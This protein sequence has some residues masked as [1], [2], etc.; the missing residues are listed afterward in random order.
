MALLNTIVDFCYGRT[1]SSG[2]MP[3]LLVAFAPAVYRPACIIYA[4]VAA[5]R[6][7][8]RYLSKSTIK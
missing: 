3:I 6:S 7:N 8:Q 1:F 5:L 4:G 2:R